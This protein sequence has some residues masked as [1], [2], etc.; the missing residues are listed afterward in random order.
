MVTRQY[1]LLES[2]ITQEDG[3][4]ALTSQNG[5]VGGLF[6]H[7]S[8]YVRLSFFSIALEITLRLHTTD[9]TRALSQ[10]QMT[11]GLGSPREVGTGQ[12]CLTVQKWLNEDRVLVALRP[13]LITDATGALSLNF[14]LSEEARRGVYAWLGIGA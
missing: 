5:V 6:R 12:S 8:D 2:A 13:T 3:T 7:E 11:G 10:L 1:Q 4:L 9:L 14:A